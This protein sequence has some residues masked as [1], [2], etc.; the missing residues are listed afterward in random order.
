MTFPGLRHAQL[1]LPQHQ[2]DYP[3]PHT[4][5]LRKAFNILARRTSGS[6]VRRVVRDFARRRASGGKY[7]G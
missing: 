6:P 2:I 1:F 4:R 3:T 5:T 7:P